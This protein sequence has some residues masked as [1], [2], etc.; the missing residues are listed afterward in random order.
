MHSA[1]LWPRAARYDK[2]LLGVFPVGDLTEVVA[3]AGCEAVILE[4]PEHLNWYHHGRRW[5]EA[6]PHVVRRP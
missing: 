3:R 6:F 2:Y 5:T 1:P 4:E